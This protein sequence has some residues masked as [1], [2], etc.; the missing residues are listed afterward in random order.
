MR[1]FE[2][3]HEHFSALY[4]A[5]DRQMYTLSENKSENYHLQGFSIER[6]ETGSCVLAVMLMLAAMFLI[7]ALIYWGIVK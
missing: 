5:E 3:S 7:I 1:N 2:T 6:D 4:D